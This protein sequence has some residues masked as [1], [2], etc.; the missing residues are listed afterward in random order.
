MAAKTHVAVRFHNDDGTTYSK[1]IVIPHTCTVGELKQILAKV[2][3]GPC[4]QNKLNL[5]V[6]GVSLFEGK[7]DNDVL[8]DEFF[9]KLGRVTFLMVM[10]TQ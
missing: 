8:D 4:D 6:H 9:G 1:G 10:C 5:L 2:H 7:N 3:E